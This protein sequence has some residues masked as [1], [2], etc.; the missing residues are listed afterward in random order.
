MLPVKT[1]LELVKRLAARGKTDRRMSYDTQTETIVQRL[2]EHER[3]AAGVLKSY[4]K[5]KKSVTIDGTGDKNK[6]FDDLS[7]AIELAFK[8]AR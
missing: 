1:L 6:I 2:E 5:E 4:Q 8:H 3:K 7:R